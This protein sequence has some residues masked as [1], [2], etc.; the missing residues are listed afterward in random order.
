MQPAHVVGTSCVNKLSLVTPGPC[1]K[2]DDVG[3]PMA[4]SDGLSGAVLGSSG[5]PE[6]KE[7]PSGHWNM[8][9]LQYTSVSTSYAE[10][11][12]GYRDF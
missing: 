6:G 8:R 2:L 1:S 7:L 11:N 10:G 3:A 4:C 5:G 9:N 12:T